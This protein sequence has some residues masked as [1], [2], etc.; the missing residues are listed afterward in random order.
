MANQFLLPGNEECRIMLLR[1]HGIIA[2]GPTPASALE[3]IYFF[4][5]AT[6]VQIEIEKMGEDISDCEMSEEEARSVHDYTM[7][8]KVRSYVAQFNAWKQAGI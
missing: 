8:E 5:R 1:H 2:I 4:E 6:K 3:D 7:K